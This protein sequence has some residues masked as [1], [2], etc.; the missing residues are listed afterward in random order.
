MTKALLPKTTLFLMYCFV[1]ISL[2]IAAQKITFSP[3]FNAKPL[4]LNTVLQVP[5]SSD[6][7]VI[8]RLKL[9]ISAVQFYQDSVL[10]HA[11]EPAYFLIDLEKPASQQIA[12]PTNLHFNAIQFNLGIDSVTNSKGVIGGALD[13]TNNMYWTWQSG[14]IN[15]KLEG[16]S[17]VC[18]TR[19][20][21]F[22]FHLGGY[23]SPY[24]AL[25]TIRLI[26]LKNES[27]HIQFD[28]LSFLNNIHL[29]DVNTVMSPGED[30]MKCSKQLATLFKVVP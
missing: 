10:V 2:P 24:N 7:V 21:K 27:I 25:Q 20:N 15:F 18:A 28:L 8:T 22:Q 6:S 29:K 11:L 5:N 14:Y 26:P 12:F 3:T 23:Q 13:P 4:Q 30:G 1:F 9:Y 19:N 16:I 17:K